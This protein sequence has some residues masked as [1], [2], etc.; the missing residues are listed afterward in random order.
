[1]QSLSTEVILETRHRTGLW[2]FHL[3]LALTLNPL[4]V[5][6]Q[7]T[8][9][10]A[11]T[12]A[13]AVEA[14]TETLTVTWPDI[15]RLVDQHPRLAAGRLTVTAARGAV[16]AAGAVPN[17]S[18][19]ATFGHGAARDGD[20][21]R[22]EKGFE[23]TVPLG[24][25][26][27]RGHKV[28]AAMAEL[29][30]SKNDADALRRDVLLQLRVLFWNLV[31]DQTRVVALADLE[32]QTADLARIVRRRVEEGEARPVERAR[33][34]VELD[35]VA[36]E[37]EA[38]RISLRANHEQLQLWLGGKRARELR[39]EADLSSIPKILDL[40]TVLAQARS[41][42]PSIKAARA[43]VEAQAA[44]VAVQKL[45]RV[46]SVAL[47]AF[48]EEELDRRA[49]GGGITVE[50]PVWNW[51]AGRIA[52]AQAQLAAGKKRL[53]AQARDLESS[54][55]ESHGACLAASRTAVR[56]RD[57]IL[58]R[59]ES[60]ASTME[61]T[62]QL[63]E[64]SLLEAIDARRLLVE[65]RRTYLAALVQAQIDCSRFNT[66]ISEEVEP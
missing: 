8:L 25:M 28:A 42:H 22:T 43:R 63:G 58:P 66:L 64:A 27:Q 62:Y 53:E 4:R 26:A 59:S 46:P 13:S 19:D 38:A 3:L 50:M 45:A 34:E 47:K 31:Y 24:W 12:A 49:Y 6:S 1:M 10:A 39:I 56:L 16:G 52:Q 61:K 14:P 44:E 15:V 9:P 30:A 29:D 36:S 2:A 60:A 20:L 40:D 5:Q 17:P 21:N 11:G 54:I 32:G 18:L 7:E 48:T 51:N 37:L 57:S 65:T 33:V 55:I 35:K 23:L 41:S